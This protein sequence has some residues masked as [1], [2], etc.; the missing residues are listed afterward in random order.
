MRDMIDERNDRERSSRSIVKGYNV[1]YMTPEELAE[2]E[3]QK[4]QKEEQ[5]AA[6]APV[7]EPEKAQETETL[8]GEERDSSDPVT[9]EQIAKILGEREEQYNQMLDEIKQQ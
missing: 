1:H 8:E 6:P 5:K 4:M 2:R 7:L 3:R 9:Q